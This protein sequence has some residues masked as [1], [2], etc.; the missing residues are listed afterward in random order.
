MKRKYYQYYVEGDDEKRLVDVLK[1]EL[2]CIESGKVDVLNVIQNRISPARI[3][4]LKKG[5]T[6]IL[7][8][9]T[10]IEKTDVLRKNVEFLKRQGAVGEVICIPQVGNVEEELTRSCHVKD[11]KE[12]T[13]SPTRTEFKTD[14]ARCKNLKNRLQACGFEISK[15]WSALPQNKFNTFGNGAEKIKKETDR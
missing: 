4:T 6:V 14:L 12:I 3:R 11:Y 15:F 5:T 13:H 8:Y 9:D 1:S 2:S 10:D 7:I